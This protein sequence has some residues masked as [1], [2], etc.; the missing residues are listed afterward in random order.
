M[1]PSPTRPTFA[2]GKICYLEIPSRDVIES[3]SF[4]HNVFKWTIRTRGDGSL[5]FDDGVTEVSGTW[6]LDKTP[7]A[8]PGILIYI[9]IEDIEATVQAIVEHGGTIVQPIGQ[10]LPEVTARFADPSG[11]VWGLFQQ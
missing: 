8:E 3:S 2:N 10:Q 4:Y 9:M 1:T 7:V 5:A 6:R 11:N